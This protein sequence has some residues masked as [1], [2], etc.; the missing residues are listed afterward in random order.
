MQETNHSQSDVGL[1]LRAVEFAAN[2][3]RDQRRKDVD[4]SPYINHPIK[5]SSLI[6]NI[7]R[8][9]DIDV[10]MAAILHD[11]IEDTCT[12]KDELENT[13]GKE[14]ARIVLEVTDDK[15]LPK[16]KR[17]ALQIEHAPHMSEKAKIVKI[18]DKC[19]NIEDVCNSPP[20]DWSLKRR[21]D[22]LNWA[23]KVVQ[24]CRGVNEE[25]ESYFSGTINSYRKKICM[26][27]G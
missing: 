17:K 20:S 25:M 18:A 16:M 26:A 15:N 10:L 24:G 11:T 8:V 19:S 2:K 22:Y 1:L 7:G 21:L 13:F 4:A 5:V 14:I 9:F 3:H 12:T 23:E 6:A 27:L